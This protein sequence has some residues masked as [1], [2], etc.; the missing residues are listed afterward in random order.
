MSEELFQYANKIKLKL[1]S[2]ENKFS[3]EIDYY[4]LIEGKKLILSEGK[5]IPSKIKQPNAI[6]SLIF[7]L[8]VFP[9]LLVKS[10]PI[11]KIEQNIMADIISDYNYTEEIAKI[12]CSTIGRCLTKN[13]MPRY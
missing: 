12:S 10:I 9:E 6:A 1:S 3:T 4:P 11:R 7:G 13:K 5:K 2:C 8:G